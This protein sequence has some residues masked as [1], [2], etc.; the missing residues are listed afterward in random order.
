MSERLRDVLMVTLIVAVLLLALWGALALRR[1]RPQPGVG[2]GGVEAPRQVSPAVAARA[3]RST[4]TPA[5]GERRAALPTPSAVPDPGAA[6]LAPQAGALAWTKRAPADFTAEDMVQ[7]GRGVRIGLGTYGAAAGSEFKVEVR[8]TSPALES[9]TLVLQ[10]DKGVLAVVPG[11]V[12]PAGPQFRSGIE[13]YAAESSGKLVVIHA[14][15][16]GRKNLDASAGSGVSVVCRMRA[17]R[18]GVTRLLVLPESSFTNGRGE[19]ENYEVTGG[20]VNIR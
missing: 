18:A 12:A 10:Y 11:S 13:G 7:C 4:T 19:E 14:G 20:E 15:T 17:L 2:E 1:G 6:A 16:P 9:C 3:P 8:I 5:A